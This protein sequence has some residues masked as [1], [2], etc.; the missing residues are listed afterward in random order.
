VRS[1]AV[2]RVEPNTPAVGGGFQ[3]GDVIVRVAGQ[4]VSTGLEFERALLERTAGEKVSIAVERDGSEKQLELALRALDSGPVAS[5]DVTWRKLG[6]RLQQANT[7][8][9]TRVNGQLHGGLTVTEVRADGPAGRA[10]LQRGDILIGLHE[11]ETL[12]ADNVV[13]VLNHPAFASF[14]PLRFF[15]IRGGQVRR[16]WLP[17]ID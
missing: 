10:G 4:R 16:G 1:V 12:T 14:N 9:V 13:F 2:E 7:E 6:L 15:I 8:S 11:W 5:N 3:R 17:Q